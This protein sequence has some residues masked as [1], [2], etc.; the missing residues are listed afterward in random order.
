MMKVYEKPELMDSAH[1]NDQSVLTNIAVRDDFTVDN[2][3]FV[4]SSSVI[5]TI[6]MREMNRLGIR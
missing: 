2:N 5:T 4:I 1:R 3:L 6:G